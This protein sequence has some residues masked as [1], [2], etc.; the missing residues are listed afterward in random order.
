MLNT[1]LGF[2]YVHRFAHLINEVTKFIYETYGCLF[3]TLYLLTGRYNDEFGDFTGNRQ[4]FVS[5]YVNLPVH[6]QTHHCIMKKELTAGTE[7][8]PAGGETDFTTKT[9][10]FVNRTLPSECQIQTTQDAWYVGAI[11]ALCVTFLF[12]PAVAVAAYCVYRAKRE[13]GER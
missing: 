10:E 9:R 4:P 1:K 13:G 8:I 11:G 3:P 2:F 7:S 5:T 6:S 12:P